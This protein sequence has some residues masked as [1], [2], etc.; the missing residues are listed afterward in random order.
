ML[1]GERTSPAQRA[2][3]CCTLPAPHCAV[4]V[5][6]VLLVL[7]WMTFIYGAV[8]T[9]RHE[10][11]P[12]HYSFSFALPG[13]LALLA[14]PVLFSPRHRRFLP[15]EADKEREQCCETLRISFTLFCA[16]GMLATVTMIAHFT[17]NDARP[18]YP[19]PPPAGNDTERYDRGIFSSLSSS[20]T[21]TPPTTTPLPTTSAPPV[22]PSGAWTPAVTLVL[23]GL[24]ECTSI[25]AALLAVMWR[26]QDLARAEESGA[27]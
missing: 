24:L 15:D 22:F 20:G 18:Y 25:G 16:L 7:A 3:V 19:P 11:P 6:A 14:F 12:F 21:T 1:L 8:W 26:Q 27:L 17:W 4:A 23:H 5:S 2:C 10:P 13:I 9:A